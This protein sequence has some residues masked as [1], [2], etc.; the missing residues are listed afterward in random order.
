MPDSASW[1]VGFGSWE[2]GSGIWGL[3]SEIDT[4][5]TAR[6]GEIVSLVGR[7]T[8]SPPPAPRS[9]QRFC[10]LRRL[11]DRANVH[12][13]LL[14]QVVPLAFEQ[15]LEAADRVGDRDVLARHAGEHLG[16]VERLTEEALDAPRAL[17]GELV[18]IAQL[19]DAKDG[20]DVLQVL[21]LLQHAL[22]LARDVVVV[23]A[24]D[25]RR[26]DRAYRAQRVHGRIDAPLGNG[27]LE[28]DRRVEVG[29]GRRRRRV[30]VIVGGHVDGLQRGD[31]AALGRGDPF[32]Q[33]AHLVRERGLIADRAWQATQQRRDL[34]A[35]LG[36]AEDIVYEQQ[37][38][39]TF[40]AEELGQRNARQ[41]DA[42]THAGR[43]VHL[44]EPQGHLVEHARLAHLAIQVIA[45]AAALAH[46]GKDRVATVLLGNIADQL[47]DD[48]GLTDARA[49]ENADLAAFAEGGDQVDDFDPGFKL[50]G[51]HGLVDQ[52]RSWPVN[53]V[54]LIGLNVAFGV[55]RL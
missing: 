39:A 49:A 18:L 5:A 27:A 43:L 19:V 6:T 12:E 8:G 4:S 54:L 42:L 10:L 34:G 3:G 11:L 16:H 31:R 24:H 26:Q 9:L 41:S 13:G 1:E 29:E 28:R 45:L 40:V 25:A 47:L 22:H 21:V 35:G 38:V 2:L 50:L 23:L 52:R 37:H 15:L 53:R 55:D 44:A 36:E 51:L 14:G 17:H 48:D 33:L 30:G 20:D 46:P 7:V 32:L